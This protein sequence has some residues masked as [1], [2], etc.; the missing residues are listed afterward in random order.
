MAVDAK[1]YASVGSKVLHRSTSEATKDGYGD[2]LA[3]SRGCTNHKPDH[4][5]SIRLCL[6][7]TARN[8]LAL[9]MSNCGNL[10][11]ES[12]EV[13]GT[14]GRVSRGRLLWDCRLR[15]TEGRAAGEGGGQVVIRR[16][17]AGGGVCKGL[18]GP[19]RE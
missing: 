8:A 18:S 1:L 15:Y 5:R 11:S 14:W 2:A 12:Q 19:G 4:S 16:A 7:S 3:I 13:W 9:A 6:P 17:R 10:A